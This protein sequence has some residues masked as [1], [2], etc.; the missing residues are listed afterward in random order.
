MYVLVI[1]CRGFDVS[2]YAYFFPRFD[3]MLTDSY[4]LARSQK[5]MSLSYFS[6]WPSLM[7][8]TYLDIFCHGFDHML[9]RA[10]FRWRVL[11]MYVF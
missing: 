6:C 2:P 1:F 9:D 11:R 4:G 8:C 5:R 7:R 3:L 10:S